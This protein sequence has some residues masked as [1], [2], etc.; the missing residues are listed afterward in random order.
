MIQH[1]LVPTDFSNNAYN[2]LF[3]AVELMKNNE[4]TFHLLNIYNNYTPLKS[5]SPSK[6]LLLQLSQESDEGLQEVYHRI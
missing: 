2:A 3:H 4:C 5:K 1:I 6:E